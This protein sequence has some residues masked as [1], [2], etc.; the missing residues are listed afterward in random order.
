MITSRPFGTLT[1][2]TPVTCYRLSAAAGAYV[3]I[4]DY[5]AT[6]QSI[7]VPNRQGAL[8]DVILGYP[9]AADYEAGSFY[10][11]ATVGRHANRIGGGRFT[12]N[13]VTYTLE[14]NSGPNHS[15]GGFCGYHQRMFVAEIHGDTLDMH[16]FSPD[17]DQG[18]PGNLRLTVRYRFA[19]DLRLSIKFLAVCDQDTVVNLTNHCYFDLSGGQAPMEQLL[20]IC[21]EQ[22]TENDEN[23]LPTGVVAS[24]AGTPFDFR[25]PQPIGRDL[26]ADCQQLHHCNGY[27]HNF[28][29]K[30]GGSMQTAARL[31]S[32]VTGIVMEEATDLP[33]LQLY[34]GNFID[35][36]NGLRPYGF[37]SGVALEGQFFPNAMAIAAFQKPILPAGQTYRHNITYQFSIPETI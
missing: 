11:G 3:D 6:V 7:A 1:D 21:A 36:P 4:L 26:S 24:V 15:H 12:L 5:G 29:L 34:S 31:Y 14:R 25:Q 33:G 27:D 35:A 9:S 32:P 30:N 10:F 20:Q 13:G 18:Y 28:V 37:R 23:T 17:G 8:T 2:G 16:L 19:D 22:Y